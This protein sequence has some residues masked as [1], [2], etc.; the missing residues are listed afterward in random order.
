MGNDYGRELLPFND[1]DPL[2]LNDILHDDG[3]AENGRK[4]T[5]MKKPTPQMKSLLDDEDDDDN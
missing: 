5:A 1:K 2:G 3:E 4:S